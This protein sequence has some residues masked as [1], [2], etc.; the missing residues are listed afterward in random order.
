VEKK[1]FD[2]LMASLEDAA[3]FAH[4]DTSRGRI[5]EVEVDAPVPEYKAPQ[6]RQALR[7]KAGMNVPR[8]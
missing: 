4:G 7:R 5:V 6:A 2:E 3:A 8:R 1:Y